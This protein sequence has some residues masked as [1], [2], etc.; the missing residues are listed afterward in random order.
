M[1]IHL[2]GEI[3]MANQDKILVEVLQ[4]TQVMGGG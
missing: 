3:I 1:E 2:K 4:G